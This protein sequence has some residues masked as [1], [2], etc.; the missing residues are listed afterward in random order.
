MPDADVAKITEGMSRNEVSKVLGGPVINNA[1]NTNRWDYIYTLNR[2]GDSPN[3]KRLTLLFE[4]DR[5]A[6]IEKDGF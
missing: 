5:V 6:T 2:S 4:N 1:N 3:V